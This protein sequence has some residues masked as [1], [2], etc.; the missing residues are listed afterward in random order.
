MTHAQKREQHRQNLRRLQ[1]FITVVDMLL[2]K[3]GKELTYI[4]EESGVSPAAIYF[5]M[6]GKTTNPRLDTLYKV[7]HVLGYELVL[8]KIGRLNLRVVK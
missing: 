8:K 2:D 3:T 5:W 6:N 4:S 1:L 7:V